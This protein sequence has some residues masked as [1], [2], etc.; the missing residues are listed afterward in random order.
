MKKIIAA[1]ALTITMTS[2]LKDSNYTPSSTQVIYK[3]TRCSDPW[4]N[5]DTDNNTILDIANFMTAQAISV[6]SIT[7]DSTEAPQACSSCTCRTG[8]VITV[9]APL[10]QRGSLMK[11]GF[12]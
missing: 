3:Q 6:Y 2:C 7:I 10:D 4:G 9:S 11:L 12:N 5:A 1:I 8:K